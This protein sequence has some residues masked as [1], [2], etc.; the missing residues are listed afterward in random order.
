MESIDKEANAPKERGRDAYIINTLWKKFPGKTRAEVAR[1][2][3]QVEEGL[4][5]GNKIIKELSA[6][7]PNTPRGE[8]IKRHNHVEDL[9]MKRESKG[10]YSAEIDSL[11]NKY[12]MIRRSM[13][14][15]EYIKAREEYI[16][17][18]PPNQW[19]L[20]PHPKMDKD[21]TV[22]ERI[23]SDEAEAIAEVA[24]RNFKDF[25]DVRKE[26]I[27]LGAR[28]MSGPNDLDFTKNMP[29]SAPDKST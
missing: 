1:R 24:L 7:R 11:C 21:G 14:V 18:L 4:S 6:L 17:S 25:R 29:S 8:I 3:R 10:Q 19:P 27:R 15:E 23:V 26:K 2:H 22:G 5:K 20:I 28:K 12:P 13:V 9:V 16:K